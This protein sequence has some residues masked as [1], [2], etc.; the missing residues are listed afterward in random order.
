M[1]PEKF[2]GV[3]APGAESEKSARWKSPTIEEFKERKN[4]FR[5]NRG[6]ILGLFK[7]LLLKRMRERTVSLIDAKDFFQWTG[8]SSP[9]YFVHEDDLANI[10]E[11]MHPDSRGIP[12]TPDESE[13]H[14]AAYAAFRLLPKTRDSSG[15]DRDG[16]YEG[17]KI[18]TAGTGTHLTNIFRNPENMYGKEMDIEDLKY[19]VNIACVSGTSN[20]RI[21]MDI[22]EL[23]NKNRILARKGFQMKTLGNDRTD[24]VI[25]YC[26]EEGVAAVVEEVM[27]YCLADGLDGTEQGVPLGVKPFYRDGFKYARVSVTSTPGED[28]TF[29]D[30]QSR[31]L[32][33]A[34]QAV[35]NQFLLKS[36]RRESFENARPEDLLKL[37]PELKN[38]NTPW[39]AVAEREYEK[40]LKRLCGTDT[41][42][43]H[44]LAF[45]F[46]EK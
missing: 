12:L 40:S 35:V 20:M 22:F 4:G 3:S 11:I 42:N 10:E 39:F 8:L 23:L 29:N 21:L 5:E 34:F 18:V 44:N 9:S 27:N 25:I 46:V 7:L 28:Y 45:P 32:L 1:N 14:Q 30:L 31:V 38:R 33:E 37:L 16:F 43:M 36:G 26:G 17:P 13:R 6:D 24:S 15:E 2:N 19:R 41:V